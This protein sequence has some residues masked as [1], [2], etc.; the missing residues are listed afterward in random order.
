MCLLNTHLQLVLQRS[1]N[2]VKLEVRNSILIDLTFRSSLSPSSRG[3][4]SDTEYDIG[5][6]VYPLG[7]FND[8]RGDTALTCSA[9]GL[10]S[11]GAFQAIIFHWRNAERTLKHRDGYRMY[12]YLHPGFNLQSPH[13]PQTYP[14]R[15]Q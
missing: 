14:Q 9:I 2:I 6:S 15:R 10:G 3:A 12:M 11:V 7:D 1:S 8:I 4:L 5:L 13:L